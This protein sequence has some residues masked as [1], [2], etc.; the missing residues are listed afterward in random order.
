[1]SSQKGELYILQN[2]DTEEWVQPQPATAVIADAVCAQT[3][4]SEGDLTSIRSYVDYDNLRSVLEDESD[5]ELTFTIEGYEVT[6][7]QSGEIT[8][9][10]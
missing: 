2:D 5:K 7:E 3:P 4:L 1:M 8:V 9:S 10:E 6:V